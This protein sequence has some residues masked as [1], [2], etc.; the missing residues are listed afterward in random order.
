MNMFTLSIIIYLNLTCNH[1]R[2]SARQ[3]NKN[4]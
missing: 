4:L 3:K 2:L 1:F